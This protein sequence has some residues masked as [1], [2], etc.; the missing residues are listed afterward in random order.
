MAQL[1][2]KEP[3]VAA[4]V[5]PSGAPA[6]I[7]GMQIAV[8]TGAG[9]IHAHADLSLLSQAGGITFL[10]L[11]LVLD[12][13]IPTTGVPGFFGKHLQAGCYDLAAADLYIRLGAGQHTLAL[14]GA[15]TASDIMISGTAAEL[16]LHEL[17]F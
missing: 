6:L 13:L 1:I 10:Q 11:C 4:Y 12:G 14:Y 15:S 17:G 3:T 2:R 16:V 8:L 5:I 9:W 7:P